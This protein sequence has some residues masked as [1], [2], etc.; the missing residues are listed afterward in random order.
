[1]KQVIHWGSQNT[2][3]LPTTFR[4]SGDLARRIYPFSLEREGLR[5]RYLQYFGMF[6]VYLRT[7]YRPRRTHTCSMVILWTG[8]RKDWRC[9]YFCWPV[10]LCSPVACSWTA[11]IT[12]TISWTPGRFQPH[13]W[14]FNKCES[15]QIISR[16]YSCRLVYC[17][18]LGMQELGSAWLTVRIRLNELGRIMEK[19]S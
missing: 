6:L 10:F 1:M 2:R 7:A 3:R 17:K 15:F 18:V 19:I 16:H 12:R 5:K 8:E 13:H 4:P 14:F 11:A 9:F